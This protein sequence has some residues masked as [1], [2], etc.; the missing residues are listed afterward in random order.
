MNN[1]KKTLI[2][3]YFIGSLVG[4]SGESVAEDCLQDSLSTKVETINLRLDTPTT[5]EEY[6]MFE[7]IFDRGFSRY[8]FNFNE[9]SY[10]DIFI[11]V[12]ELEKDLNKDLKF[13]IRSE[14]NNVNTG[15]RFYF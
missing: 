2:G 13:F 4:F 10:N 3:S 9:D 12:N 7:K 14:G 1:L 15:I 8:E 5:L 6:P 11:R